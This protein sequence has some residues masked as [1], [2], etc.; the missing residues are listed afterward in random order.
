MTIVDCHGLAGLP[1]V[2]NRGIHFARGELV[3]RMDSDDLCEPDR[4]VRTISIM[5]RIRP[6]FVFSDAIKIRK[7]SSSSSERLRG[8][9]NAHF[10][11]RLLY[12]KC[13]LIHPTMC[14]RRSALLQLGGYRNLVR[15]EDYD[16]WLRALIYDMSIF[17]SNECW[18]KYRVHENQQTSGRGLRQT[19]LE[20]TKLKFRLGWQSRKPALFIGAIV[21][22]FFAAA[23]FVGK[24]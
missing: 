3:A 2:L 11:G 16:L 18:I 21:D 9:E 13:Y 17:V 7:G 5:D 6:D 23:T 24:T 19:F 14:A 22:A 1:L 12:V 20:N 10:T 15:S 4:F 8:I